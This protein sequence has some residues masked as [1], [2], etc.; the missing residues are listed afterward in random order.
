MLR[1]INFKINKWHA[2][3]EAYVQQWTA[4]ADD[5]DDDDIGEIIGNN[6]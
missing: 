3:G 5:E 2:M 4:V 1:N 6:N